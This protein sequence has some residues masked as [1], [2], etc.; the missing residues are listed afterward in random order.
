MAA[1]IIVYVENMM[2]EDDSTIKVSYS[3]NSINNSSTASG[4]GDIIQSSGI[5]SSL[6]NQNVISAAVA[7]SNSAGVTI[8]ALDR[9]ILFHGLI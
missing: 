2:P 8:G 9:K 7:D 5:L 3:W 1:Y 4:S 6:C